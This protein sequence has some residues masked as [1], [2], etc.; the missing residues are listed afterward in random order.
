MGGPVNACI[1]LKQGDKPREINT[2]A[3]F[4]LVQDGIETLA[5]PGRVRLAKAPQSSRSRDG[6]GR[7]KEGAV[8]VATSLASNHLRRCR[9]SES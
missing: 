3:W 1:T 8:W 5:A 4:E 2:A 7:R 9:P 6:A